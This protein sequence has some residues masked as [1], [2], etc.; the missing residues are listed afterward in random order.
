MGFSLF[1]IPFLIHVILLNLNLQQPPTEG[2]IITAYMAMLLG[3]LVKDNQENERLLLTRLPNASVASLIT[4]LERFV[5]LSRIV[6][7]E[8]REAGPATAALGGGGQ[9]GID[10]M[11]MMLDGSPDAD[12]AE[13]MEEV[14]MGGAATTTAAPAAVVVEK[15][16]ADSLGELV[17]V[18]KEI[19]KK[20]RRS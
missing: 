6:E 16:P 8:Q 12:K 11:L 2:N 4:I 13:M 15:S 5:Q 10:A 7:E 20:N 9:G 19:E 18:L 1:D 14:L 17:E 3:F